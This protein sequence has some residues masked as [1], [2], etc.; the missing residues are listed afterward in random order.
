M[1]EFGP[2]LYRG[3]RVGLEEGKSKLH[4]VGTTEPVHLQD[5]LLAQEWINLSRSAKVFITKHALT[6]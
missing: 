2:A 5:M 6:F 3:Y 1:E 4:I